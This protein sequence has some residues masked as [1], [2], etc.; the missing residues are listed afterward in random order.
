MC[1]LTYI[2]SILYNSF[3]QAWRNILTVIK[4]KWISFKKVKTLKQQ[5]D[6]I[7]LNKW[8]TVLLD[9]VLFQIGNLQQHIELRVFL[10]KWATHRRELS[11]CYL[12]LESNSWIHRVRG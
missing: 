1:L 3:I 8:I 6:P 10:V 5:K 11:W 4:W 7:Y 9:M 2:G 12:Y